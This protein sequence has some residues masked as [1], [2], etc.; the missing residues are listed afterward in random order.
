MNVI[1]VSMSMMMWG[2]IMMNICVML[3]M[4]MSIDCDDE[5]L[6][7]MMKFILMN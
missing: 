1:M 7:M 3:L 4:R 6:I 2:L 5:I